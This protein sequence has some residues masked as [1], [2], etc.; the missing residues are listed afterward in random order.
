M[1]SEIAREPVD[2]EA[3]HA[4]DVLAQIIAALAARLA[5][6]QVSPP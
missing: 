3:H 5:V 2:M 1:F 6:P 4:G